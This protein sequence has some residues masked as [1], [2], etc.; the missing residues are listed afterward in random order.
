MHIF[1]HISKNPS[2]NIGLPVYSAT[3]LSVHKSRQK[4][5]PKDIVFEASSSYGSHPSIYLF[6][7]TSPSL[8]FSGIWNI[9]IHPSILLSLWGNSLIGN[10]EV[11]EKATLPSLSSMRSPV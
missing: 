8:F 3:S 10:F 1:L 11:G 7:N 5:E 6:G 4:S 2:A 9:S